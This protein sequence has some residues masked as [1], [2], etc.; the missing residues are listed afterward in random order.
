MISE[1]CCKKFKS[2][3][4]FFYRIATQKEEWEE[5][6]KEEVCKIQDTND[7]GWNQYRGNEQR[8]A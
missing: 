6:G 2:C 4:L 7:S 1:K 3:L 5:E 8:T